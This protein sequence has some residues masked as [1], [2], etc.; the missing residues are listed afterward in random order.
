MHVAQAIVDY[1]QHVWFVVDRDGQPSKAI[2]P[3]RVNPESTP[4]SA[5]ILNSADLV[6]PEGAPHSFL[7]AGE[8]FSPASTAAAPLTPPPTG[9]LPADSTEAITTPPARSTPRRSASVSDAT[10]RVDETHDER[11]ASA[12][13]QHERVDRTIAPPISAPDLDRLITSLSSPRPAAISAAQEPGGYLARQAAEL[14]TMYA[15]ATKD[16][17]ARVNQLSSPAGT[18]AFFMSG[19]GGSIDAKAAVKNAA[20]AAHLYREAPIFLAEA[21]RLRKGVE[22]ALN[23]RSDSDR[24]QAL[25]DLLSES[26][27]RTSR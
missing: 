27:P 4:R 18:V 19:P 21:M 13:W 26:G 12:A 20:L 22:A 15:Q 25:K 23:A 6:C 11:V 9:V 7:K 1:D 2:R 10:P 14:R 24:M 5:Q 16:W 3:V 17:G 8:R